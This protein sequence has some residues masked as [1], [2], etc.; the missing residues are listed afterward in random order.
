[1]YPF[2]AISGIPG[3]EIDDV[4]NGLSNPAL[5]KV[6]LKD[7]SGFWERLRKSSLEGLC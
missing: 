2:L 7:R 3:G 5:G 4:T 1:M 6:I